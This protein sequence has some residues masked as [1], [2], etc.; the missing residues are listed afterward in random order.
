MRSFPRTLNN[1][2]DHKYAGCWS[3]HFDT[4]CFLCLLI[5]QSA[6]SGW[7]LHRA[8]GHL[9][10]MRMHT[11]TLSFYSSCTQT[12]S[13]IG[14]E[15]QTGINLLNW[16][17]APGLAGGDMLHK[18]LQRTA[19]N[20]TTIKNSSKVL[21]KNVTWRSSSSHMVAAQTQTMYSMMVGWRGRS[22]TIM[23]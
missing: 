17:E 19:I 4:I 22:S 13:W 5:H 6:L 21:T 18:I 3:R 16:R 7:I 8:V 11:R 10:N 23:K 12:P 15:E 2:P 20:L 1:I 14:P 9:Q